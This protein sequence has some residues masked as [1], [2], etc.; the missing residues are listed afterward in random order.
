MRQMLRFRDL[1]RVLSTTPVLAA[2]EDQ[3]PMLLYMATTNRVV[4]IV[5]VVECKEEAQE[6]DIQRSVYYV[7]KVLTESKQRYLTTRSWHMEFS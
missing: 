1:K 7:S 2:P 5:I 3:K 4:S 6:Y